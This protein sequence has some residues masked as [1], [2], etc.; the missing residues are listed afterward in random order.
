MS[1]WAKKL[2]DLN[3]NTNVFDS[4]VKTCATPEGKCRV[5]LCEPPHRCKISGGSKNVSRVCSHHYLSRMSSDTPFPIRLAMALDSAK[6]KKFL[7]RNN[8]RETVN[9]K[10][11]IISFTA[12]RYGMKYFA[13]DVNGCL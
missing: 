9:Y 7:D 6:T 12:A 11:N 4:A 3:E 13:L 1:S 8:E 5:R 10:G 2:M